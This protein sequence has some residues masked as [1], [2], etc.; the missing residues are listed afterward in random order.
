M[1]SLPTIE[2][3]T[4]NAIN[5]HEDVADII[6]EDINKQI[7][8]ELGTRLRYDEC[9][10]Q[11]KQYFGANT[12]ILEPTSAANETSDQAQDQGQNRILSLATLCY[13]RLSTEQLAAFREFYS[14]FI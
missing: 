2:Y 10:H 6:H 12:K 8:Q 4:G 7:N 1:T 13:Y 9:I 11:L 5:L 3:L 14:D